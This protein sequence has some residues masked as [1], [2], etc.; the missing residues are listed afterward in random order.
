MKLNTIIRL[1]DGRE[2]TICYHNLDGYGGVWDR[3]EFQEP[4]SSF[5]DDLPEPEFM[6][7]DKGLQGRVGGPESEC[8]GEECQIV[9]RPEGDK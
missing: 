8:V 9:A 3:Q 4:A 7:R 6:L 2:G 1:P 5:S